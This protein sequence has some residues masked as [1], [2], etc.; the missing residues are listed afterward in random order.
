MNV[1]EIQR[2]CMH[3]GPGVRTT[4]FLKGCPLRCLWCHNPE[5]QSADKE[6]LYSSKKCIGCQACV[7]CKNGVHTFKGLEHDIDRAKCIRC[8]ECEKNC[9]TGATLIC[10]REM[11][12]AGIIKEIKKDEAFYG[13][14]GGVTLSGGEPFLQ[15]NA[16]KLLKACKEQGINTAVETCGYYDVTEA[17]PY[18]DLFL[19]D[20]K[21]TNEK[22]HKKYT[23]VSNKRILENLYK[24][25]KAGAKIRLRCIL[26]N[27]VNTNKEHYKKVSDTVNSLKNCSGVDVLPYHAYGGAKAELLGLPDNGDKTLIPT[28][29]QIKQFKE[30]I[31]KSR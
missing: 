16:V 22:R 17:V 5:M 15:K 24:A 10:G 8:G 20:L 2:F 14:Q 12:I 26:V 31:N 21:D 7:T 25:D 1:A 6:L 9:P 30:C 11:T 18:V 28:E 19:W 13:G 23:G 3:D 29:E 27:G 4:V